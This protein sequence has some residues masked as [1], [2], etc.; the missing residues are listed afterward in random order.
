MDKDELLKEAKHVEYHEHQAPV[1]NINIG[2]VAKQINGD[3]YEVHHGDGTV[4]E[5]EIPAVVKKSGSKKRLLFVNVG[6]VNEENI[7][8]KEV[9]KERFIAYLTKHK[10]KSRTLTSSTKDTVNDVIVCFI[11]EWAD[12]KL[13]PQEPSA[14]AISRFLTD[15]C[16]LKME[17]ESKTYSNMLGRMIKNK[18]YT[19]ETHRSVR[20][21]FKK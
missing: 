3:Y 4:E 19:A 12:R 11:K 9:E 1:Y 7:Q 14:A 13:I 2:Y 10:L 8:V 21:H 17:V 5:S 15:E 6:N 16:G 20:E 18:E